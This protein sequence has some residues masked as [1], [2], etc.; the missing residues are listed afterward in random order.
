MGENTFS[1]GGS[2]SDGCKFEVAFIAHQTFRGDFNLA[3]TGAGFEASRYFTRDEMSD[4]RA[5][6]DERLST[7][8]K[9]SS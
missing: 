7:F 1:L 8:G 9:A 3:L 5:W 2:P 4:L 6:I